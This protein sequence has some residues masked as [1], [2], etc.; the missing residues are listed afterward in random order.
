MCR[1]CGLYTEADAPASEAPAVARALPR[2]AR[3]RLSGWPA[4]VSLAIDGRPTSSAADGAAGEHARK[5]WNMK[6][7]ERILFVLGFAV[8]AYAGGVVT[9]KYQIWP[10]RQLNGAKDAAVAL[11]VSYFPD[12]RPEFDSPHKTGGVTRH[13]PDRA[14]DGLTFIALRDDKGPGAVV[15]DMDGQ[16]L[17]R[18]RLSF[19]DAFPDEAPHITARA[20]DDRVFWHGVHLFPNGDVLLN[21]EGGNFPAGSGL[22]L[23]DKDSRIKWKLARNTHHSIDVQ[24]D[25]T[26]AVLAH[27]FL[28]D[29]VPSCNRYVLTPYLADKVLTVSADGRELDSFSVAEAFCDSPYKWMMMPFG[30]YPQIA[31]TKPDIEDLQH[32]ND[33]WVLR[34]EDAAVFPMARAGDYMASF[35]FLN[36]VAVIDKDTKEIKW[37]LT[38]NFVRQHDPNLLPNG[39]ILLYDN[40]GGMIDRDRPQGRTRIIEI[41]PVTHEIVWKYEGGTDPLDVLDAPK[42]GNVQKLPNGNVLI[43]NSWQGRLLEVTG[44]AEPRIVWEYVNLLDAS[45]DGGRVG[46]MTDAKRFLRGELTFLEAPGS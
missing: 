32:T 31:T 35:A 10:Y 12:E 39:N 33:I 13:D 40:L 15:V 25:G 5:I 26:I 6:S 2:T 11:W 38:G 9:A 19:S 45:E 17:H 4:G 30:T 20:P 7:W 21:L 23:I 27:D 18:W 41:N 22:V 42:G 46:A 14:Q 43:S 34:P 44:D 37:A 29:G 3:A 24:P 16:V 36:M 28:P 1:S 8:L